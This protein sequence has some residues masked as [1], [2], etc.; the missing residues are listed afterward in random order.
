MTK[1]DQGIYHCVL[2][3]FLVKLIDQDLWMAQRIY[4]RVTLAHLKDMFTVDLPADQRQALVGPYRAK[5]RHLENSE[6]RFLK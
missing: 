3:L 2:F 6:G 1:L 4:S 5:Y